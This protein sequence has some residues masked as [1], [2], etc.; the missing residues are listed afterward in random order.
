MNTE[1]HLVLELLLAHAKVEFLDNAE[2]T[3]DFHCQDE[4]SWAASKELMVFVT[5]QVE[6]IFVV[7]SISN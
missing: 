6:I 2:E 3:T 4:E 7:A 1:Q 5:T